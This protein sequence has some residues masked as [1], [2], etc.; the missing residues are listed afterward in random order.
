MPSHASLEYLQRR[1]I[2]PTPEGHG[3]HQVGALRS[4]SRPI[5]PLPALMEP[6]TPRRRIITQKVEDRV[7]FQDPQMRPFNPELDNG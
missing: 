3:Q 7:A 5:K 4:H 2:L 6:D 1:K